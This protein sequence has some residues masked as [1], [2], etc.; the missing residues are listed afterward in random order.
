MKTSPKSVGI[1]VSKDKLT[2]CITSGINTDS[3]IRQFEVLN[4]VKGLAELSK[5]LEKT[6]SLG[7]PIV[8]ESTAHYHVL[9]C[10]TLLENGY[11]V[12]LINPLITKQYLGS[13]IRKT[14]TDKAD[15]FLLA[16]MGILEPNQLHKFTADKNSILIR[17]K[18][19][20]LNS[21]QKKYQAINQ[22][23][24]SMK[25]LEGILGFNE[26]SNTMTSLDHSLTALKK[27]IKTLKEDIAELG[28]TNQDVVRISKIRGVSLT[29]ASM[30]A[31]YLIDK[32]FDN[33]S[34]VVAF[35]GLDITVKQ[36]GTSVNGRRVISK[37]GSSILRKTLFQ[38]AWGLIMHNKFFRELYSKH[39]NSGKHYFTCLNIVA[40]KF[41]QITF[42]MIKSHSDFNPA[43]HTVSM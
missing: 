14:K 33:K 37:R 42:G 30:I 4:T 20:C 21:L 6:N 18:V 7:I 9:V 40:R 19:S 34:Q 26:F 38:V 32:N 27:A 11:D 41:L 22:S 10:L 31:S 29:S 16:K 8:V 35:A 3:I 36:S 15:A 17:K 13:N 25:D 39:Y 1:D 24:K 28:S 5:F 2:I 23:I 43:L 12:R